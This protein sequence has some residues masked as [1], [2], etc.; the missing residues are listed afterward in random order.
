MRFL[1][2]IGRLGLSGA[3]ENFIIG[4]RT[5]LRCL[6]GWHR[7]I[8]HAEIELG[9]LTEQ[10]FQSRRILQSRHLHQYAVGALALDQGFHSAKFVDAPF[11]DLDRLL[12]GLAHAINERGLGDG[13]PHKA[14]PFGR[15]VEGRLAGAAQNS[16]KR[17]G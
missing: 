4:R 9:S 17:L 6:L 2:Q 8:D 16:A 15:D 13:E 12:D 5:P 7:H 10:L 1:D 14:S 11:D 3:V